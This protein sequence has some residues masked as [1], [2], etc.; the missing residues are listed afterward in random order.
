MQILIIIA[1]TSISAEGVTPLHRAVMLGDVPIIEML[2]TYG[3]DPL[4]L[5]N[6]KIGDDQYK[7]VIFITNDGILL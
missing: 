1:Y 3:A 2:L 5:A 4:A 7:Y 6:F